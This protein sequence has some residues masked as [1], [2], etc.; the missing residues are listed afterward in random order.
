MTRFLASLPLAAVCFAAPALADELIR[1]A[2]DQEGLMVGLSRQRAGLQSVDKAGATVL[3]ETAGAQIEV[4]YANTRMRTL[5]GLPNFYTRLEISLGLGQQ[6][7]AGN[8]TDPS[9]G[10]V[11][12]SK[13]PFDVDT[14]SVRVRVGYTKEF[15]AGGRMALTPFLGVAQEAW[16]RGATTYSDKTA[17]YHYAAEIGLLGQATLTHKVVLGADASFGRTVGAWQIDQGNLIAPRTGIRSSFALYLDN[18]TS[19]DWHQRL[20]LRQTYLRYREPAQSVGMFE[21]RRNSALSL[22]LEFG[23]ERDLFKLLFH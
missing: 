15:G 12:S 5:F 2:N 13:G 4:G 11:G 9:T 6:N 7:F 10:A 19:T 1:Q 17:Y 20:I 16:L 21:P 3:N 18:R 23:T 8:P 22:Q 14:E